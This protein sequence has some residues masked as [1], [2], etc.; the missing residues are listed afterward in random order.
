MPPSSACADP[1]TVAPTTQATISEHAAA[2]WGELR[3]TMPF[4][5]FERCLKSISWTFPVS[6]IHLEP[7]AVDKRLTP[8][9][10]DCSRRGCAWFCKASTTH[11]RL[12]CLH[13]H[14]LLSL[15]TGH[16]GSHLFADDR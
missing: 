11:Q 9:K 3:F 5:W 15:V 12:R 7:H 1:D 13:G 6:R 10:H 16:P 2:N 14:A 8:F 4:S